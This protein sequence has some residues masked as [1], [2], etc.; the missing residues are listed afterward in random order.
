[1]TEFEMTP[2]TAFSPT[3]T[4]TAE[5]V[6][7]FLRKVYGWMFV[8]LGISTAVAFALVNSGAVLTVART[9]VLYWGL[10][11]ATFGLAWF[12]QARVDKLAPGTAGLLFVVYSALVGAWLS[13]VL[14]IYTGESVA[15]T[16]A[17]TAG[18]VEGDRQVVAQ[19]DELLGLDEQGLARLGGVVNDARH[20]AAVLGVHRH[21]VAVVAN[22]DVI[23]AQRVIFFGALKNAFERTLNLRTQ[24]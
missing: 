13:P 3:A 11:I 15:K 2:Q 24:L 6:T 21:H 14:L 22:G 10:W 18:M 8:G 20:L 5:R 23:V 12:V 9:P 19:A 7:A 4:A 17:V 16:L 1:M